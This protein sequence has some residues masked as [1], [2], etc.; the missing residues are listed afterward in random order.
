MTDRPI[1]F[2]APMVRALIDG[3]KT[4]TRRLMPHQDALKLAYAPIALGRRIFN[5]AGEEEISRAPYT[6]GDRLWVREAWRARHDLNGTAPRDILPFQH[7]PIWFEADRDGPEYGKR[8]DFGRLR[9]G[10]HMP[11]WASRLTLTVTDV[12]VQRLQDISNDDAVAE[13]CTS[14]GDFCG[15]WENLHGGPDAWDANPWVVALTFTAADLEA[16]CRVALEM[17]GDACM[18]VR[19]QQR[20]T[21]AMISAEKCAAAIRAMEPPADLAARVK[22]GEG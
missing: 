22:G 17:A 4:Q 14:Y 11:R 20:D 19:G 3:R 5:Y 1:I 12:R 10:I 16:A 6:P 18:I 9:S 2:S 15:L 13:G 21:M 7:R 8:T